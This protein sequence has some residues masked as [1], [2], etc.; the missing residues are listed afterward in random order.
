MTSLAFCPKFHRAV[1]LVGR[2]WTGVIVRSMMHGAI[3][4]S[5]ISAAIP[6]LSDRLLSERLK[7][8][9]AQGV[10]AR[11]VYPETPVRIE[12]RLTE[13]G[14]SLLATV[15]AIAAWAEQWGDWHP[16]GTLAPGSDAVCNEEQA[17]MVDR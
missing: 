16:D 9:E 12:Y 3:R 1:E 11:Q 14:A 7:E 6:G 8:L 13:K 10:V 15:E 4:F 17:A 5:D 2:R